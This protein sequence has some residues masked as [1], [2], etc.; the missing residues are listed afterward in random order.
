MSM[1]RWAELRPDDFRARLEACSVVYLPMGL[2]EPH[3]HIAA[4]GLDTIKADFLCDEAA[5]RFGGIVAPTQGYQIHEAGF[6]AR[7]LEETVGEENPRLGGLP[8]HVVCL[9]FL[10]QLRCFANAGFAAAV[11]ISGHAGGNQEDLRRVAAAFTKAFGFKVIVK[12]DPELVEGLHTGDHAGNY[13]ISQLLHIRPELVDLNLIPRRFD[14]N[15]G[16]QLALGKDAHEATA[17]H[18]KVILEDCLAAIGRIVAELPTS[19]PTP[20]PRIDFATVEQLWGSLASDISSWLTSSKRPGQQE[21]SQSSQWKP[22]ERWF[23][24]E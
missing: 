6:H 7:W 18:G 9:H 8:P 20:R 5:R 3:G 21:V 4:F 24:A 12:A 14:E 19:A 2:C 13:E 16:G 10:Y 11:V 17:A 1:V 15:S 23:P 22:Y